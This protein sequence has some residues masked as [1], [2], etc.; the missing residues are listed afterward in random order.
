MRLLDRYLLR[1]LI[2]PFG[3]CVCGFLLI[4][5]VA[6]LLGRM[7]D[8]QSRPL[9]WMHLAK[10][11]LWR[12]PE[13]LGL[14]LPMALLLA[15]L[16]ALHRHNRWNE[17]TAM[18]A[19]GWSLWRIAFPYGAVGILLAALLGFLNEKVAPVA[20]PKAEAALRT[21]E[22]TDE[23]PTFVRNF[24]FMNHRDQRSWHA[25][26]Y[27][28]LTGL[29]EGPQVE[30]AT[31]EGRRR[32]LFA[33]RAIHTNGH[34]MF[35]DVR[36]FERVPQ[37]ERFLVPVRTLPFL[38]MPEFIETPELLRSA[39]LV[40]S[41]LQRRF[42]RK[43]DLPVYALRQYARLNPTLSK[44]ERAWLE[45]QIHGR[46]SQPFTCVV[47]VLIALPFGLSSGRRNVFYGV[48]GSVFV[49]FAYFVLQQVGLALG[50]GG[51]LL[52]WLAAWCPNLLFA[53]VGTILILRFR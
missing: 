24:G 1:R 39:H 13:F 48:A 28:L 15:L 43:L 46:L 20:A 17:I 23:H 25:D 53:A 26:R 5:I 14:V 44:E 16:Y 34:W 47:V 9:A 31:P 42:S 21:R 29:M 19:A 38:M 41:R 12:L 45:T 18:R 32:W 22:A 6:D 36:E 11:Y 37:G 35:Y 2:G 7:E 4:W 27:D 33:S 51:H 49:A 30:Y 40:Q 50:T 10:Y 3:A 52:P 8:F